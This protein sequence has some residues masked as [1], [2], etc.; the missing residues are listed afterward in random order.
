MVL[1]ILI[2]SISHLLDTPLRLAKV[3]LSISHSP[4]L[5]ISFRFQF[6]DPGLHLQHGFL[7]SLKSIGFS[8]IQLGGHIL[9]L[10]FQKF[11]IPL[12]VK[13]QLLFR[14]EFISQRAASII[15]FLH[16]SSE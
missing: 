12:K 7:A 1:P 2:L 11:A 6:T 4:G 3:L 5:S 15:A 13:S 8:L 16:F 9:D 10:A 14:T